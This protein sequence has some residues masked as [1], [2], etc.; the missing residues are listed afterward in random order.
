MGPSLISSINHT[1]V[2]STMQNFNRGNNRH[3]LK[4]RYV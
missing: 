4:K 3:E 2:M 1:V